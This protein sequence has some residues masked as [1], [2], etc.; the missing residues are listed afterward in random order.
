MKEKAR[1]EVRRIKFETTL[2]GDGAAGEI[3]MK[4][5]DDGRWVLAGMAGS[6]EWEGSSFVQ[7]RLG[8]VRFKAL[9]KRLAKKCKKIAI[10]IE[11]KTYEL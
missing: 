10:E 5:E 6:Q 1:A 7:T 2:M 3:V 4:R 9:Q 11:A 8:P